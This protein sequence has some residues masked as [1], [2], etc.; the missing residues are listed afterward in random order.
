[1]HI[2]MNSGKNNVKKID[3]HANGITADKL[4]EFPEWY[5]QVLK[6]CEL[7]ENYD[8]SG[9]YILRPATYKMWESIQDFVNQELK[10]MNVSNAYFPLFITE[11]RLNTEKE[12][13]EGFS[14]EVAWV[15]H[16]G[17]SKLTERLAVRPTSETAMYPA[18][19]KWIRSYRDLP[20]KLNQWTSAVRWETKN[21]T[22]FIRS[23]E[24]LWQEGHTAYASKKEADEEVLN[25]LSLY[26]RVY[27]ELLACPVIAG[28]KTLVEK[29]AGADYTTSIE[30]FIP[31][32]GRGLQGATSHS[33]GQNF[34]KM[35]NIEYEDKDH[36]KQFAWQ[37]SWGIT[38]RSIGTMIMLHGD[39]NGLILPPRIAPIQVVIVPVIFNDKNKTIVMEY[40]NSLL[41]KLSKAE[42]RAHLDDR[43]NYD[44]GFKYADHE[45]R[46]VPVRLEIGIRD[47][48]ANQV[49]VY[50]RDRQTKSILS[51]NVNVAS[52]IHL[53][54]STIQLDML[55]K[56]RVE[57]DAH[58]ITID[59]F[60]DFMTSFQS[61][62]LMLAPHCDDISCI[63]NVKINSKKHQLENKEEIK[64]VDSDAETDAPSAKSLCI[65]F[66][67]PIMIK[68]TKC[69]M[70]GTIAK[71]YTLFGKSY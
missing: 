71:H 8:V 61:G 26:T 24:F 13:V 39:N 59:S 70:C 5:Q 52:E 9:C 55:N 62:K 10:K 54:L 20:L 63:E 19:S 42:I 14:A 22:P 27:E 66:T 50:R 57:R 23:R 45:M 64:D 28:K 2:R 30:V 41:E 49:C 29:F 46:G 1:M 25:I 65:P 17:K 7:I 15:T 48:D 44:I 43:N 4:T 56:A 53:L 47:I 35:F 38:T 6:K 11:A 21:V 37:N 32:T 67:Q 18:Y 58:I 31:A 36:K 69:F 68:D 33:L 16:A 34:A 51:L 40:C 3:K 60:K 12:H